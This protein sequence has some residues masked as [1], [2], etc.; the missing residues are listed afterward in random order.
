MAFEKLPKPAEYPRILRSYLFDLIRI[1]ASD[2][3][4]RRV[5][6]RQVEA[7]TASMRWLVTPGV[8]IVSILAG[9]FRDIVY[10]PVMAPG[11]ALVVVS[12]LSSLFIIPDD[13]PHDAPREIATRHAV[14]ATLVGLGWALVCGA[15]DQKGAQNIGMLVTAVQISLVCVGVILYTNL[16]VAFFAFSGTIAAA[17][18]MQFS[19]SGN[20]GTWIAIPLVFALFVILAKAMIDQSRMFVAAVL[21]SEALVEM[22][23]VRRESELAAE[24]ERK[25]L[26]DREAELSAMAAEARHAEMV[27]LANQ[28]EASVVGVVET[29]S[30]AVADLS[31]SSEM[32]DA[33]TQNAAGAASDVATQA[34]SS[35][36][37]V[38]TLASAANQ[39]ALSIAQIADQIA[40]HA[41]SSDRALTLATNS[42]NAVNDMSREAARVNDIVAMIDDL[43][44]QTNLL[45]L[46]ATIE[47]ARA[48][49]AG[50]G[51]AVVAG[52]V[53][54]LA[55]RAGS[56]TQDV[57][58]QIARITGGIGSTVAS[59]QSVANE[60]DAVARIATSIAA[61]ISQ[62]RTATD[63][64]GREAEIVARNAED[65]RDRMTRLAS[66]A[67]NAG[68]LTR[69]L[70]ETAQSLA[71]EANALK[72]A[73]GEFL[74]FLRAA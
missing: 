68:A 42:E 40:D 57:G 14:L 34:A 72:T 33:M 7:A 59:I 61:S 31:N 24:A 9:I 4:R 63:E 65:M 36:E 38:T 41:V 66:G 1:D 29:V 64:I 37:A 3:A 28:F 25:R 67:G 62:Q 54:S 10:W 74:A 58:V 56:A 5:F 13:V 12:S 43:T 6:A 27:A 44:K 22:Q 55:S 11:V 23:K 35:S 47:A 8:V 21:T 60:I 2:P 18:M 17:F 70:T 45:A 32:L 20:D 51:F 39:L 69:G 52:E 19:A 53:K 71:V 46:N 15:I 50:R 26:A 48:G 30:K 73:T 49:E 16:P